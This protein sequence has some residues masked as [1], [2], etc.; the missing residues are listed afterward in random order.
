MN[1]AVVLKNTK[2]QENIKVKLFPSGY[3]QV[4]NFNF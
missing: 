2:Q 3:K 1:F 4:G